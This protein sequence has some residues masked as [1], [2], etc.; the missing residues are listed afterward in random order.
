MRVLVACEFS[1]IVRDAFIAGGHE[2]ISCDIIETWVRGPHIIGDVRY[3][4]SLGW[5]MMI[6]FPPCTYLSKASAH[7]W[8]KPER[9]EHIEDALSF[10]RELMHAPIP[11]IAIENPRGLITRHIRPADQTIEPYMFGHPYTKATQLWLKNVPPLMATLVMDNPIKNITK[12]IG[13]RNRQQI[14]SLTYP[15]IA[16]AMAD[17][18]G[19]R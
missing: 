7:L 5:D 8:R 11:R 2:A 15:G 3:I 10:V 19:S 1:G 14:R 17:Q 9:Q 16:R 18:W 4:L 6:A 13:G 12:S